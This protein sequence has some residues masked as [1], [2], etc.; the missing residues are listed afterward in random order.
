MS[1]ALRELGLEYV[2]DMSNYDALAAQIY[3]YYGVTDVL[4]A[5][6]GGAQSAGFDFPEPLWINSVHPEDAS[7]QLLGPKQ[8]FKHMLH[9]DAK[10]LLPFVEAVF[11]KEHQNSPIFAASAN[12][13]IDRETVAQIVDKAYHLAMSAGAVRCPRAKALLNMLVLAELLMWREQ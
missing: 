9:T 13:D 7:L 10:A 2:E 5:Q 3:E 8:F 11:A 1:V 6:Y 4:G 12:L